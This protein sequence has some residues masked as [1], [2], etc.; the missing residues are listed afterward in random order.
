GGR[1]ARCRVAISA[2]YPLVELTLGLLAVALFVGF[3]PD[4]DATSRADVRFVFRVLAPTLLCLVFVAALVGNALIDLDWFILP[5]EMTLPL[6]PM[7]ILTAWAV[8]P[9]T[10]VT[11]T[12]AAIG[13]AVGALLLLVILVVY[14][15]LTGRSGLGGGDWK[16]LGAIGA[17]LGATSLPF[18]LFA[19]SLQGLLL[20]L[21][22]RRS[23]A[24][25]ELPPDPADMEPGAAVPPPSADLPLEAAKV[26]FRQLAVPFGPFL[27]LAAV[28]Y[29]LLRDEI[30][31]FYAMLFP[32]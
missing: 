26:P 1:C 10:G 18:V 3:L 12:D 30:R 28:E 7:G 20:A 23:F 5:N 32:G 29:L 17:Y 24:V 25:A 15:L 13:A 19:A 14:G 16:L 21:V 8:G 22:L 11:P 9:V 6:I 31:R 4:L 2:R 27:A